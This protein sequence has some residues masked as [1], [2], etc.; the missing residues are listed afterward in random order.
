VVAG[1]VL[2]GGA[3]RRMGR[4]KA[5]VEVDGVPMAARAMRAL[6]ESGADPIVLVGGD[7]EA[8]G[9]LGVDVVADRWPGEGPLAGVA[10][11]LTTDLVAGADVV[12]VVATDQPWLVGS[13]LVSLVDAVLADPASVGAVPDVGL[14][15]FDGLPGAWRRSLGP[16]VVEAVEAG[17]RRLDHLRALG[18]V[19]TVRPRDPAALADV[20]EPADL[21][22]SGR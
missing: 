7:D 1:A 12:L 22:R 16:A 9:R 4:D 2:T 17:H 3:S 6:R 18:P 8:L 15:R 10:T 19:R 11:A 14:G 13:D 20:D 5:L 21:D